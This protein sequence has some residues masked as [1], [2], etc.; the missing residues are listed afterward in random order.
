MCLVESPQGLSAENVRGAAG[1]V[2]F[3]H[4][5]L[6]ESRTMM[7]AHDAQRQREASQGDHDRPARAH[8]FYETKSALNDVLIDFTLS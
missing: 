5:D 3:G 1:M 4:L 7:I 6:N 2:S 8:V